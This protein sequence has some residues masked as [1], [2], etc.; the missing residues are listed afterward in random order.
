MTVPSL[1]PPYPK[2]AHSLFHTH[3]N[4]GKLAMGEIMSLSFFV[5]L[6][7]DSALMSPDSVSQSTL[8]KHSGE[9]NH[10]QGDVGLTQKHCFKSAS[11]FKSL[12]LSAKVKVKLWEVFRTITDDEA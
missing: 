9:N 11:L 8:K 5:Y 7:R 1:N 2:H 12:Y 4:D 3:L 10:L 6:L